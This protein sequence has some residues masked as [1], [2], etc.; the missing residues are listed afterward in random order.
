MIHIRLRNLLQLTSIYPTSVI[1]ELITAFTKRMET[2]VPAGSIA[3]R[4]AEDVF[5][6]VVPDRQIRSVSAA[7]AKTC[8]GRYVCM[9]DGVPRNMEIAGAIT[10]LSQPY[11][12]DADGFLNKLDQ[13]RAR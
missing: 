2:L 4:W 5:C 9:Q 1:Q 3:G 11:N 12:E 7:L 8:T 13:I 6:V 10:C